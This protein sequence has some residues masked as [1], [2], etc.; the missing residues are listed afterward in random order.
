MSASESGIVQDGAEFT[1]QAKVQVVEVVRVLVEHPIGLWWLGQAQAQASDAGNRLRHQLLDAAACTFCRPDLPHDSVTG[2]RL[3]PVLPHKVGQDCSD[4]H[5][6]VRGELVAA[7]Y[8]GTQAC[9]F[10][11][12]M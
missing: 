9:E 8:D 6:G 4:W 2:L 7:F 10:I 3:Y 5:F 12:S 1:C 11:R